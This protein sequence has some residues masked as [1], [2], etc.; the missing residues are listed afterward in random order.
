MT[1][2]E[3]DPRQEPVVPTLKHT[4]LPIQTSRGTGSNAG[5]RTAQRIVGCVDCKSIDLCVTGDGVQL[6]AI[7]L[8]PPLPMDAPLVGWLL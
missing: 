7:D 1:T 4:C 3:V 2:Q 8:P 5:G 6:Q